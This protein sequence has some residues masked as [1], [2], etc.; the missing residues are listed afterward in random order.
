MIVDAF[1]FLNEID[2][3]ESR[4]EYLAGVVDKFLIVESNMTFNGEEKPLIF[5]ENQARFDKWKYRIIYQPFIVNKS[6]FD[7]NKENNSDNFTG[8]QWDFEKAQRNHI[9][10]HF[11]NYTHQDVRLIIGDVDE[12]PNKDIIMTAFRSISPQQFAITFEQ[13]MFYYNFNKKQ[14]NRWCGSVMTSIDVL[15][16]F[17][18]QFLRSNRWTLPSLSNGGWHISNFSSPENIKYKI[19]NFSQQEYNKTEYTDLKKIKQRI[20][21]GED[22]FDRESNPFESFNKRKLPESFLDRFEKHEIFG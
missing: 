22:L 5:K 17:S 18:P 6:D 2:L 15:K 4:I 7:W 13:D 11:K 19:K 20:K 1:T 9:A 3:L 8:P 16:Q 10:D 14:V 21:K 12:I